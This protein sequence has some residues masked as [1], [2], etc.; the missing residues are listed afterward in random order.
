MAHESGIV[1]RSFH[2]AIHVNR[3]PGMHANDKPMAGLRAMGCYPSAGNGVALVLDTNPTL[4]VPNG[5]MT[6]KLFGG[7][8]FGIAALRRL[9]APIAPFSDPFGRGKRR[10]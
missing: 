3:N 8:P 1:I 6:V 10:L 4:S 7:A 5:G 2:R 9:F